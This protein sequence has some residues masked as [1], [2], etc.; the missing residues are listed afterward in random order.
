MNILKE[1]NVKISTVL[2]FAL[3]PL[4]GFATDIYVPSFPAM[5]AFFGTNRGDIQL[6]LVIFIISSG[7]AQL[8]VGSILDAFGR[9]RLSLASL[10]IFALASFTIGITNSLPV[11]LTMRVVQGISVALIVVGKRAFF[12]DVYTG[13]QLKHYTSLFAIIWSTAPIIAPFIGGFLQHFFGW[14][15]NFYFL[16]I[17]TLTLLVLELVYSGETLKTPQSFKIRPLLNV[18]SSILSTPDYAISVMILG[19]CFSTIMLYNMAS[20][21]IIENVFH[22]S[23][24]ATGNSS[25]LSGLAV[26]SGGLLSKALI[27]HSITRKIMV[28]GPLLL[29]LASLTIVFMYIFPNLI[30]M[31]AMVMLIHMTSGFTYN[32]FYTYA[33]GRFTSNA[34]TVV[35]ITSGS[36]FIITSIFSY[37]VVNALHIQNV[38]MLGVGYL[39]IA[40]FI[41]V[42]LMLFMQ[43]RKR[44][45]TEEAPQVS[46]AI[47]ADAA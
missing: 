6:S 17:A 47:L 42:L 14:E 21:F 18:Y 38:V 28:V 5:A 39:I 41:G 12:M 37:T 46:P 34:G 10:L 26:L 9:Y 22:Q 19:L 29:I 31:M 7:I 15:S 8:F 36:M 24:V 40:S 11:L 35:G 44:T 4:S 1:S 16:A 25:L 32:T 30:V 33:L 45:V 43:T 27:N 20:P 13:S 2:A 3:M 23:A